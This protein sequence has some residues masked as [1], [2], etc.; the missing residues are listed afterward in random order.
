MN[1]RF[2]A[3]LVYPLQLTALFAVYLFSA[4]FGLGFNAV[5]GFATLVWPPTGIALAVLLLFGYRLWPGI[6]LAAF[7]V[8]FQA[9]ASFLGA[10]GIGAGN[11]VEALVGFYLLRQFMNF[12]NKFDRLS[13]VFGFF[14]LAGLVSTFFSAT[15]GVGSLW[16]SGTIGSAMI[17]ETWIAWWVGDILGNLVV[18][19]LILIWSKRLKLGFYLL[20][21]KR[22]VEFAGLAF[23]L[24]AVDILIF[25]RQPGPG[26]FPL[27]YLA[28]PA[29]ILLAIRFGART[30]ALSVFVTAAIAI[31][32]T[33]QNLGPFAGG[34]VSGGLLQLQF[35]MGIISL[36]SLTVVTL[37]AERRHAERESEKASDELEKLLVQR[38][39]ELTES[40]ERYHRLVE[41]APDIIFTSKADG[42]LAAVNPAFEKVLGWRKEEWT[43]KSLESFATP[44]DLGRAQEYFRHIGKEKEPSAV[45]MRFRARSGEHVDLEIIST[46]LVE[47]GKTIGVFGIARD[48]TQKKRTDE[49]LSRYTKDL[50]GM[51]AER[52]QELQGK[53]AK[54]EQLNHVLVGRELKMLEL[55]QELKALR[56]Q[57]GVQE[58]GH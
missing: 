35:F 41:V 31:W 44:E 13:D 12:Q 2:P 51:V 1:L 16:G 48:V 20:K 26:F 22:M 57:M 25:W 43:G 32:G 39:R 11:T 6:L 47:G 17:R 56:E 52:T 29:L 23:A 30:A 21:P 7:L 19:P 15:I 53:I 54:L 55:K 8:N 3:A 58:D 28:F 4:K 10:L 18:A 38:T 34:S 40:E 27:P 37:V 14:I 42:A 24:I 5:S 45:T 36:T 50:E 9:G 46:Q 33:V 49:R